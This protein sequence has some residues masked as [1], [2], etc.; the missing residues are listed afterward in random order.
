MA[1]RAVT[2]VVRRISNT[3]MAPA[4]IGPVQ[5]GVCERETLNV[6]GGGGGG[7]ESQGEGS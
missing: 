7:G 2:K 3:S 4:A 5:V 1:S 6:D